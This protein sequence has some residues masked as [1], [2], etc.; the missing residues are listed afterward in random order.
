ML[1]SFVLH[2]QGRVEKHK[3]TRQNRQGYSGLWQNKWPMSHPKERALLQSRK[4]L[5]CRKAGPL[6]QEDTRML[7]RPVCQVMMEIQIFTLNFLVLKFWQLMETYAENSDYLVTHHIV[8]VFD[9]ILYF[10]CCFVIVFYVYLF[11][12]TKR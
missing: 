11:S 5:P 2:I 3:S 10:I 4:L 6:L 12:L 7:L 8:T 1:Y 9:I